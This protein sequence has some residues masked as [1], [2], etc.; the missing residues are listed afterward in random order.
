[1]NNKTPKII[2]CL[3]I[4]IVIFIGIVWTP[5]VMKNDLDDY[6]TQ[7]N[8]RF[9][10]GNW[11]FVSTSFLEAFSF[12]KNNGST[13]AGLSKCVE[14]CYYDEECEF[15]WSNR[16]TKWSINSIE[17]L[18]NSDLDFCTSATIYFTDYET[19]IGFITRDELISKI[20]R[21]NFVVL[22]CVIDRE[23]IYQ[24]CTKC[25]GGW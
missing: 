9:G 5:I 21:K 20:M 4:T 16:N 24:N 12:K 25:N 22:I 2:A 15:E 14:L 18:N 8:S 13:W 10:E 6:T 3:T 17:E 19:D 11:K 7:C 1:M 23:Y